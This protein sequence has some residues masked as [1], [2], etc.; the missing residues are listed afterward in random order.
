MNHF[1]LKRAI[2]VFLVS[3]LLVS[4]LPVSVSAV[5][6]NT[7]K[8]EVVYV[9]LDNDGSVRE[10]NVVNIF[11][12]NTE[13]VIV[14]YGKYLDV[15]NMTT[16][17]TIDF[18]GDAIKIHSSAEKLYY[19]GKLESTLMPWDIQIRYFLDG[20]EYSAEEIAGKSGE[21]KI[22]V[23]ITQNQKYR[24]DFYDNYA[25]QASLSFDTDQ[26]KNI[27]APDATVANVGS[28]KQLTYTILPGKGADIE[29][30]AEVSEF[31]MD[32]I[33]INGIPLNLNIE[34]DDEELMEQVT[35]LLDAISQLDD[36]AAELH[37]GV[38]DLQ[39]GAQSDL[40]SGVNDLQDGAGQL[41]DG[42][43]DLKDGGSTLQDG[44]ADLQN[45][46]NALDEGIH[47]LNSGIGQMQEALNTL[48]RQSP[49]LV[50]GSASFQAA[51]TQLQE[52]LNGA[53]LTTEDL[54]AL[55]DASSAMKA[56]I[57][58][59]VN[60]I[61]ALQNHVNFDAYKDVMAQNGLDIDGLQQ[62]NESAINGLEGLI[63]SLSTQIE[64][65][66]KAGV[67]TSEIE[68]QVSQLSDII[69]LLAANNASI[70]GTESYLQTVSSNLSSLLQGATALQGNYGTFD[71]KIEE[72]VNKIGGLAYQMSELSSAIN[73][74]V[75]E[76][77]KLDQGIKD[78][79]EAV[80]RIVAGYSQITDGASRLVAGSSALKT[81]SESLY[82]GTGELLSGIVE[83]YDGTGTLKDGTGTLDDGVAELLSGIAQLY[84][85]AGELKDG[86]SAMREETAGMDTEITDKIDELI[87]TVTGGDFE[88][89]SFVSDK[90]TNVQSVQ[91]VIKADG[92]QTEEVSEVTEEMPKK[93]TVWQKFLNL[94]G[95]YREN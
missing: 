70:G 54:S 2:S 92:V 65:L 1:N 38:F 19:E 89:A 5:E 14:D 87:E 41:H 21:I 73:T 57:N 95:L 13:G 86:T 51:L 26:C 23:R 32:G 78:Y 50:N 68:A 24:G 64:D 48:N 44:A 81:G 3:A 9:N 71:G 93:L 63:M 11:G 69:S 83:I 55:T 47:S 33:S 46:V 16:T 28:K 37:D 67:D 4:A 82:S 91:F 74:L 75:S 72:L 12:G 60:G 42:A 22:T 66:K 61:T 25:L 94:F 15:R 10:I 53:A 59:L 58:D 62:K 17:D 40:K 77:G 49:E 88:V 90:N 31:E 80:A 27:V 18:S 35:E 43:A 8:E 39:D 36:G 79:T 45:G 20:R 29:I 56:G 84:D 34:V 76:Y 52:A 85:G 6:A 7:D 30:T